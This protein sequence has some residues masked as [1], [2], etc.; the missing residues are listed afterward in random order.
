[1]SSV[2]ATWSRGPPCE[3]LVRAGLPAYP[4][5]SPVPVEQAGNRDSQLSLQD[6]LWHCWAQVS[7]LE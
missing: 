7:E 6:P 3:P 1:M 5:K 4:L 2:R